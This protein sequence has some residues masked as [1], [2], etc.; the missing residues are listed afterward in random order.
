MSW[1]LGIW[2][3]GAAL[4]LALLAF[5]GDALAPFIAAAIMAYVG[6]PAVDALEKRKL[7]RAGGAILVVIAMLLALVLLPLL[8]LPIFLGQLAEALQQLPA[9]VA[10]LGAWLE[11]KLPSQDWR[12]A[13]PG[14]WQDALPHLSEAGGFAV[15]AVKA[16]A[17]QLGNVFSLVLL[18]LI[19][20]LAAFYLLRDWHH[21][22]AR[23][24]RQI[25]A[26]FRQR[27]KEIATVCD[28]SLSSFLRGQ[29]AVI[30]LMIVIYCALLL[31]AGTPYSIAIGFLAGLLCFIPYAGF[32]LAFALA[33]LA[34]GLHFDGW[35]TVGW[36]AA[37]LLAGT[38]LES[39]A[40]TP[41]IVGDKSG[42]GPV[43][44][45]LALTVM[46]SVFGFAG[47]LLALPAAAVAVALWRHFLPPDPVDGAA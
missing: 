24:H 45:L 25:P 22:L 37:A 14:L 15:A 44:V 16:L 11:A 13:A 10:K 36:T 28:R 4:L 21:V 19:A 43:A 7:P 6:A 5:A 42:L 23:L 2:C 20:P 46:G 26:P 41:H 17:T 31:A 40:L 3:G 32:F 35:A 8:V 18:L 34:C 33:M 38:S 9:A 39:F 29:L 1:R 30:F 12:A 27:A 47:L